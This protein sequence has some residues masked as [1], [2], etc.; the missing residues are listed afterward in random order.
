MIVSFVAY[1]L[2]FDKRYCH[3]HLHENKKNPEPGLRRH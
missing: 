2:D 1:L 3:N